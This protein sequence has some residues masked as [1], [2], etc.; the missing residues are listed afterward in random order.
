MQNLLYWKNENRDVIRQ[1]VDDLTVDHSIDVAVCASRRQS[2]Q[3]QNFVDLVVVFVDWLLS[4]WVN[5]SLDDI[6]F[7]NHEDEIFSEFAFETIDSSVLA[8]I[9]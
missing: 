5:E 6:D 1:I 4:F 8:L 2:Q 9:F 7:V 3:E